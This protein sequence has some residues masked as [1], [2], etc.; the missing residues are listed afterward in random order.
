MIAEICH[1]NFLQYISFKL[2]LYQHIG[3][4]NKKKHNISF[5]IEWSFEFPKLKDALCQVSLELAQRFQRKRI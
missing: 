4:E 5:E 3:L 2:L 1:H